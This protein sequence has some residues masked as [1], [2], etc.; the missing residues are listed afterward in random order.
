MIKKRYLHQHNLSEHWV[1][2]WIFVQTLNSG[3]KKEAPK[4]TVAGHGY[5]SGHLPTPT[6]PVT[7]QQ[8]YVSFFRWVEGRTKE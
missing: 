1:L 4:R 5:S 3:A 6:A 8:L 2:S 7:L